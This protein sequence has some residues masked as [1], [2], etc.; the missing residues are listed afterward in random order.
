LPNNLNRNYKE[1]TYDP[2][3]FILKRVV[4]FG[5]RDSEFGGVQ[6]FDKDGDKILEAGYLQDGIKKEIVLSRGERLVGIRSHLFGGYGSAKSPRQI[7]L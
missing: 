6:F 5:A 3:R 2:A 4:M 1:V 7:D